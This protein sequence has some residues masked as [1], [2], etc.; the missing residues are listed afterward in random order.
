MKGAF[1]YSFDNANTSDLPWS[2]ERVDDRVH[3]AVEVREKIRKEM[4]P[5]TMYS[6]N[7]V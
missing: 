7:A 1:K 3:H 4:N 2:L 5:R 6:G